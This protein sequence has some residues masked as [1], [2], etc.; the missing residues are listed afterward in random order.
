M[1]NL[2]ILIIIAFLLG[3]IIGH[4]SGLSSSDHWLINKGQEFIRC[5]GEEWIMADYDIIVKCRV[6][7]HGVPFPPIE[8]VEDW[9]SDN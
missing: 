9:A 7:S 1:K 2:H 8:E 4:N 3:A 5:M 6:Y